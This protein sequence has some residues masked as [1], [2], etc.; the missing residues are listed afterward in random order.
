M[1]TQPANRVCIVG[2]GVAGLVTAKVL[3][4]DGFEVTVFDKEPG[5][6]GVWAATRAYPGL[7]TNNPRE[8]YAFSDFP[9]PE[10]TDEFPAAE[11]VRAYLESYVDH[12]RLRSR[13]RLG[14]EVVSVSRA[15]HGNGTTRAPFRVETRSSKDGSGKRAAPYDFVVVCNGVFSEPYVPEIEGR[16]PF[17]GNVLHSCEL[18]EPERL[19][20]K[21]VVVVGAG[22]SALDCATIAAR[23]G[24][25]C[26]LVYRAP[27][28]ILPRYFFGRI[29]MDRLFFTRC[30][31]LLLPAYHG[32]SRREAAFRTLLAPLLG[33]WWRGQSWLIPRLCGMPAG[34]VPAH[35][36]PAGVETVGIGEEF[37]RILKRGEVRTERGRIE[38]FS[39][40]RTLRLD[41]GKVIEADAVVF[42]T[43]WRQGVRFLEP[44]L[45]REVLKDGRFRLYRSI[46]PPRE[47][48]LGF[49]GYASSASCPFTAEV[50]AHWLAECFRGG[51]ALPPPDAMDE[52]IE[53]VHRWTARVFPGRNEGYFIGAYVAQHADELMRDMG[54]RPHRERNPLREYLAP[55]WAERYADLEAER[56]RE[57]LNGRSPQ[58]AA[59]ASR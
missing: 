41:S 4:R 43:G 15:P 24:A 57:R 49:V 2:A 27:H 22:K 30:S 42:A 59:R 13:I 58:P 38:A 14:T 48:R 12:F 29:R 37:Y 55:L 9:Y 25:D 10:G 20:G 17:E 21:A 31:E 19:R 47:R 52:E 53:R 51:L 36:L 44:D 3:Q 56:H 46:L 40:P 54:L 18:L 1:T 5:V 33:L 45:Q 6:G 28:W 16:E 39:G 8:T 34:M 50:S 23:H 32:A 26:T 11:Q 35:R 7:R